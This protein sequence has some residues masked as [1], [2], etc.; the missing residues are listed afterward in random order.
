V[1]VDCGVWVLVGVWV[2]VGVC[3]YVFVGVFDMETAGAEV[4]D[5]V[6]DGFGKQGFAVIHWVQSV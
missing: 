2:W 4:E 1:V 6:G 3:V 5:G